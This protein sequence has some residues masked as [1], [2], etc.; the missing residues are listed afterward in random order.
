M[1]LLMKMTLSILSL[2]FLI[3]CDSNAQIET[4]VGKP[5][6]KL[7]NQI[8]FTD[9]LNYISIY[10]HYQ[11]SELKQKTFLLNEAMPN[12]K[13]HTIGNEVDPKCIIFEPLSPVSLTPLINTLTEELGTPIKHDTYK[14]WRGLF[15]GKKTLEFNLYYHPVLNQ[16]IELRFRT[17]E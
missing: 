12:I 3:N 15:R 2:F 6:R 9:F 1:N 17:Q 5:E 4:L 8:T 14:S 7:D 10:G 16:I 11:S 13:I